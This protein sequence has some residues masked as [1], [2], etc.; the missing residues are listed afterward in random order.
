MNLFLWQIKSDEINQLKAFFV[1]DDA[2]EKITIWQKELFFWQKKVNLV[3]KSTL[4]SFWLRHIIDCAQIVP[5]LKKLSP[6][7]IADF[8]SGAGFPG[9]LLAILN[10]NVTLFE[11]DIKKALFLKEMIRKLDI[12]NNCYVINERI[13][14]YNESNE[15]DVITS[16]AMSDIANLLA[17]SKNIMSA[18]TKLILLKGKS[19]QHEIMLAQNNYSFDYESINSVTEEQAK[20][21]L[22]TNVKEK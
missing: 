19:W 2:I 21:L 8:G 12:A 11:V 14:E 6:N 5:I 7:N 3:S 16:R 22:L 9:L 20:I 15:F 1:A 13:E 18:Q 10:Y 17:I 4:P